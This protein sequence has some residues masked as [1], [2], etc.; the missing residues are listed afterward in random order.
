LEK[1][2]RTDGICETERAGCFDTA[3]D[4]L[5]RSTCITDEP[6][7]IVDVLEEVTCEY[8]EARDDS[9]ARESLDALYWTRL[10]NLHLQCAL[11]EAE[12]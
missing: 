12:P 1:K 5:D 9:F 7:T 3:A 2:T 11:A 10:G 8:F 6:G 4:V